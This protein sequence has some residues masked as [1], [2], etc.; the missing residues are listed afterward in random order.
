MVATKK[1]RHTT[2]AERAQMFDYYVT[3]VSNGGKEE[4][5]R[6]FGRS[7][8]CINQ[9]SK[10]DNW[11]D[12]LKAIRDKAKDATDKKIEKKVTANLEIV[13]ELKYEVLDRIRWQMDNDDK[14]QVS[15]SDLAKLIQIEEDLT[16]GQ[17]KGHQGD[18][19]Y[20]LNLGD[21]PDDELARL[22]K[23]VAGL[24]RF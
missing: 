2:E 15:V 16:N 3:V 11:A 17:P 9:V 19:H 5:A 7:V 24:Y 14:Y 4:V 1:Q 21:L 6:K 20:H 23:N 10:K 22:R 18:V 13:Q 12:R 8:V